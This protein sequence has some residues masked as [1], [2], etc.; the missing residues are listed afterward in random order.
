MKTY[1]QGIKDAYADILHLIT[2]DGYNAAQLAE[3]I[4][5]TLED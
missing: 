2:A 1:K 5:K 4:T 3:L